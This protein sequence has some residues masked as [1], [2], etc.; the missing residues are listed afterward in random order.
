MSDN[1]DRNLKR[2]GESLITTYMVIV[3]ICRALPVPISLPAGPLFDSE[4]LIPAVSRVVSLIEDQPTDEDVKLA[5]FTAS[6]YWLSAAKLYS[7]YIDRPEDDTAKPE[8]ELILI[9]AAD[10]LSKAADL[11]TDQA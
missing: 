7:R 5:V 6:L 11:L 3:R 10:A 9:S 1:H 4:E 2:V 8:I